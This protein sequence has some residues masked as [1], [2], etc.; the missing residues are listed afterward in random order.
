MNNTGIVDTIKNAIGSNQTTTTNSNSKFET[1]KK[2]G[3]FVAENKDA[4]GNLVK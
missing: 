3:Q 1:I 4:L 2:V